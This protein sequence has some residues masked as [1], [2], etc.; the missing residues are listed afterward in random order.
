MV[1]IDIRPLSSVQTKLRFI[2]H[3]PYDLSW[4]LSGRSLGKTCT[5]VLRRSTV[6]KEK[7]IYLGWLI[8]SLSYIII[9]EIELNYIRIETEKIT[10]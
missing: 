3:E 6:L 9:V 1:Y 10:Q 4:P 2:L 5:I 8:R 7:Q